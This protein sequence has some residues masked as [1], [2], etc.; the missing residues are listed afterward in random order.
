MANGYYHVMNRGNNRQDIFLIEKDRK[1]FMEMLADSCEIYQVNLVAYVLM[2]NHLHL[3]VH[4][5]RANLSKF[6]RHFQVTYTVR[7]NRHH[8]RSG[9]V[10]QGRFKSLLVQADEYLLPLSR[11]IHLNPVRLWRF[12]NAD[13]ATKT[14]CLKKFPW[15]SFANQL[16]LYWFIGL[17]RRSSR[18]RG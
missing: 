16:Q 14:R 1:A 13:V 17:I 2:S 11:H 4:T 7:F 9:H 10:F 3:L 15:S 6:M 5:A 8:P 12:E 18:Q